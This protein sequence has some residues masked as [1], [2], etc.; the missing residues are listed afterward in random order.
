MSILAVQNFRKSFGET[1][2]LKGVDFTL[3]KGQV[4]VIIGSSGSGKT[5]LLRCLTFLERPDEGAMWVNGEELLRAPLPKKVNEDEIREK[6]SHFGLVFQN[7]NLFPQ[8]TVLE[9]ICLAPK[10]KAKDLPNYKTNKAEIDASIEANAIGLLMQVGLSDKADS[11]PCQLSGGQQQRVA[12]ARALALSPDILCFDE[13]TSA[14]DPELTAEVLRVLRE[15]ANENT[16]MIIV[17]HE[18][19]F[20]REI[21]DKIIFMDEGVVAAMGSPAE[22][23]AENAKNEHLR[24][25]IRAMEQK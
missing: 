17:T 12:I 16:T 9:N 5:T 3:E 4:L 10:L 8:Y 24:R 25:F 14:L 20:A 19:A 11:Y 6:R 2:V 21:A 15:L 18:M 13:P 1:E 7:F 22:L 23:F